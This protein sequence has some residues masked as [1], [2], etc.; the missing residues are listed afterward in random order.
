[1]INM[2]SMF[3]LI[4]LSPTIV[5]PDYFQILINSIAFALI[6]FLVPF[7]VGLIYYYKAVNFNFFLTS[8]LFVSIYF[9]LFSPITL[10]L[11]V[12]FNGLRII[13]YVKRKKWVNM[14]DLDLGDTF[15][16]SPLGQSF[17][18][19]AAF[20]FHYSIFQ[21]AV[22]TFFVVILYNIDILKINF[23]YSII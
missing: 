14:P 11:L 7:A 19:K 16:A 6:S 1:M 22:Y 20:G 17:Y 13:Y 2:G 5:L 15:A 8:I 23:L 18:N 10:A 21:S 4:S 12:I 3:L 9:F